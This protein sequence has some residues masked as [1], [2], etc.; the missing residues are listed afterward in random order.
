MKETYEGLLAEARSTQGQYLPAIQE[1]A[2]TLNVTEL[3][4]TVRRP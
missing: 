3:L 1:K 2:R 4:E